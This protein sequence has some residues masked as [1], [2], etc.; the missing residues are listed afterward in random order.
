M[1]CFFFFSSEGEEIGEGENKSDNLNRR[2]HILKKLC[3][4]LKDDEFKDK[5]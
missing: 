1:T 2:K 3:K 4:K 5:M